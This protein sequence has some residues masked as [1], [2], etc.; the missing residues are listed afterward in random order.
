MYILP[1]MPHGLDYYSSIISLTISQVP[2]SYCI[3]LFQIISAILVPFP[4]HIT[5]RII[6]PISIKKSLAGNLI[7][8]VLK[9]YINLGR[10]DIIIIFF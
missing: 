4:F 9:Q 5:F 3:L 7:G 8:I 1:R 6:L 2:F 10:I